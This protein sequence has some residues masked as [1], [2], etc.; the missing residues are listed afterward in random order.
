[1]FM[2]LIVH[3][4]FYSL[5]YSDKIS[6]INAPTN[7]ITKTLFESF[8]N[9]CVNVS[10]VISGWFGIRPSVKGFLNFMFQCMFFISTVY[11]IFSVIQQIYGYFLWTLKNNLYICTQILKR[12]NRRWIKIYWN[13]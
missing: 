3:A 13:L 1:M 5:D 6:F 7:V 4:D 11:A 12:E 2:V 9:M 10:V 8:S